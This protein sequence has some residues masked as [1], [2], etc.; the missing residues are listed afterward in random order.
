MSTILI[1][2]ANGYSG[3]LAAEHAAARGLKAIVAGRSH[4][5]IEAVAQKTGF[6]A[7]V[8][9]LDHR[10][11]IIRQLDG[12]DVVL[13]CAGPFSRTTDPMVEACL[14]KGVHYL[15]ITG[16]I[17]IIERVLALDERARSLGVV[18]MPAC[19]FDV[20][21]T[22]CMARHLAN[23]APD[24][25]TLELAFTSSGG[26]SHGTATT[27]I[28]RLGQSS[29][30]RVGG[31]IQGEPLAHRSMTVDFDGNVQT[32]ISIPWGDIASAWH[33]TGIPNIVTYTSVPANAA[34]VLQKTGAMMRFAGAAPIKKIA[35]KFVDARL[36]GPSLD[37]RE[38]GESRVWGRVTRPDGSKLTC[39]LRTREAYALTALTSVDIAHRIAHGEIK[40]G[41]HTPA[42]VLGAE[43]ILNFD[44]SSFTAVQTTPRT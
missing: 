21:P 42:S 26:L 10:E 28:E 24:A 14:Q 17:D 39:V 34:R 16:E 22:D 38:R 15:D 35:Q 33:T 30:S 9:S 43:Y 18:L 44:G 37:R 31:V 29:F 11:E 3:Y 6:P 1:Y 32:C 4:A 36:H 41:A 27:M 40:P 23:H 2:G 8:F 12:V 25:Q 7:R 19:G 13:N 20:V 5:S